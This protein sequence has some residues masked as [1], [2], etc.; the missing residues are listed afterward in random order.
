MIITTHNVYDNCFDTNEH[1]SPVVNKYRTPSEMTIFLIPGYFAFKGRFNGVSMWLVIMFLV[2]IIFAHDSLAAGFGKPEHETIHH[3]VHP[4]A[5]LHAEEVGVVRE[6]ITREPYRSAFN[7]LKEQTRLLETD[8]HESL[9]DPRYLARLAK[10]QAFMH[11]LTD[12]VSWAEKAYVNLTLVDEK[13]DLISNI[14]YRGLDRATVLRDMAMVYDLCYHSW[15]SGAQSH[16]TDLLWQLMVSVASNMGFE[17]NY[18][19]ASNWMGVRYASV[20][21]AATVWN[22]PIHRPGMDEEEWYSHEAGEPPLTRQRSRALPFLWDNIKRLEE[23]VSVNIYPN[24]WNSESVNYSGYN[25]SFIL[26]ALIALQNYHKGRH[27]DLQS[28][29]PNAMNALW[30]YSIV[31]LSIQNNN[32]PGIHPNLSVDDPSIGSQ[33]FSMAMR[34]YPTKQKPFIKWM[35]QYTFDPDT[36]EYWGE[37]LFYTIIWDDETI[38]AEN[39]AH[40]G[41]LTYVDETPGVLL[42]RNRYQD[43]NDIVAAFTANS[44]RGQ[45][46]KSR[47]NLTFRIVGL[48]VPWVIGPGRTG[49]LHGQT[50]LFPDKTF[51]VLRN[52]PDMKGVLHEYAFSDDG[53]GSALASGSCFGLDNH[54]RNFQVDYS[55]ESGAAAVFIIEDQSDNGFRWRM[56]TPEF[57]RFTPL[58][59]GYLLTAPNGATLQATVISENNQ[60]NGLQIETTKVRFGGET[61]RLNPGICYIGHCYKNS[62]AIDVVGHANLV[63]VITLQPQGQFHPHVTMQENPMRINVGGQAFRLLSAD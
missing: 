47:D 18:P 40:A 63:V 34:A 4:R 55:G 61:T 41:W 14:V 12:E 30:A 7:L 36:Y 48:G 58:E 17:A 23:H 16:I 9:H 25:A 35:K 8:L 5:L 46:H 22:D 2:M 1:K 15:S 38:M 11:L 20:M 32:T 57:N 62:K 29:M 13:S 44:A 33:L 26:P 3:P 60:A 28:Y 10:L 43:Q 53:S 24:G 21:L 45:G 50:N 49:M 42:F 37:Q 31:Y 52:V 56:N 39:P 27:F 51:D 6:R 19:L 59:H 54:V